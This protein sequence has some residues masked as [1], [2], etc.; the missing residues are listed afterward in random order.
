VEE[1]EEGS[2]YS[3]VLLPFRLDARKPRQ[4]KCRF[5]EASHSCRLVDLKNTKLPRRLARCQIACFKEKHAHAHTEAQMKMQ[6]KDKRK[7]KKLERREKKTKI[8]KKL[9]KK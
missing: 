5:S 9:Q 8:Q 4:K 7:S 3:R 6:P 2:T 1:E